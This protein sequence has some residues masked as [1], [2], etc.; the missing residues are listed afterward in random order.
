M[1]AKTTFEKAYKKP[2][3][4][5]KK[6]QYIFYVFVF[7]KGVCIILLDVNMHLIKAHKNADTILIAWND[8]QTF[9]LGNV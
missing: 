7:S 6:S 9:T 8:K 2:S 3:K 1:S 5:Y 4:R